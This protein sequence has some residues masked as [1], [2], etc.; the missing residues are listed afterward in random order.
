MCKSHVRNY[1]VQLS[2]MAGRTE[3]GST[4]WGREP[5]DVD[6]TGATLCQAQSKEI[7]LYF[8]INI[9]HVCVQVKL[10]LCV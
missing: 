10:C 9:T 6:G 5:E 2:H 4:R 1:L 3:R 8:Y 7:Q